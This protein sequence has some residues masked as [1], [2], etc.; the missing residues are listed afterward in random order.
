MK[1]KLYKVANSDQQYGFRPNLFMWPNRT[2]FFGPVQQLKLHSMG[3]VAINVGLYQPFFMK[4]ANG[5][6]IPY[7]CAIIPA[8]CKHE[9]NAYGNIV[10]SLILERNSADFV[11]LK[12]QFSFHESI[13]T[14][15][16]SPQWIT[17]FCKIYEE[18]PTKI[19]IEQLINK[20]LHMGQETKAN[21]DPRIDRVMTIIQS[22]P[23]RTMNQEDL[24][25]TVNLSSS[26]FRHLFQEQ[27]DV[28]F[29][30]YRMWQR[31]ISAM[32][33]L[34]KVDNLTYAAMEAGFTDSAH[35]N[36]CFQ[37][38]LGVNPSLVFRNLDR[39]EI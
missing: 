15:I 22:D 1:N 25:A 34:H 13:V 5:H 28:R 37:S 33:T 35:F 39:F 32:N 8:G 9:L 3:S 24:A 26:R 7:R 30:S 31:I 16:T 18:K 2:L 6:D 17:T 27:T 20:L 23:S 29:R 10:A 12:K 38:S 14:D 11:N 21:M 4:T 36:R 19:E